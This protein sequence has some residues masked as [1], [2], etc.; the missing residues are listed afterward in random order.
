M[1]WATD[2]LNRRVTLHNDDGEL[3]GV[4]VYDQW[5]KF[6][7]VTGVGSYTG[8]PSGKQFTDVSDDEVE[9]FI[10]TKLVDRRLGVI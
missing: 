5:G 1:Y 7:W 4:I 8:L 3:L 10:L 6:V 9:R 2:S